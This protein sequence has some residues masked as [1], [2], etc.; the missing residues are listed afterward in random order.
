MQQKTKHRQSLAAQQDM[1]KQ[2][3]DTL[4]EQ[5]DRIEG[6]ERRQNRNFAKNQD[7]VEQ[8]TRTLQQMNIQLK[9]THEALETSQ[10]NL[11]TAIEEIENFKGTARF[12]YDELV[13]EPGPELSNVKKRSRLPSSVKNM[14]PGR[15]HLIMPGMNRV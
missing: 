11:L 14:S 1:M 6:N 15:L 10:I 8:V 2:Q 5:L 12:I 3:S 9:D 4:E 7:D 13:N